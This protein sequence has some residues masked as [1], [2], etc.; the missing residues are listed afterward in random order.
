MVASD[1]VQTQYLNWLVDVEK[2]CC[3][4]GYTTDTFGS[5]SFAED[6]VLGRSA[7]QSIRNA[8]ECMN[9]TMQCRL[10]TA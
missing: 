5:Y 6:F 9:S 4:L 10:A 8:M 2:K 1:E 7:K 3:S